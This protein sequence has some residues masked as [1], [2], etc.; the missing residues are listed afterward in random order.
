MDD[1]MQVTGC[2]KKCAAFAVVQEVDVANDF[3]ESKARRYFG[4]YSGRHTL[5]LGGGRYNP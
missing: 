5:N 1:L 3:M 4:K 2:E